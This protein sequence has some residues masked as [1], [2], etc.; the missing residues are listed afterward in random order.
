MESIQT[1]CQNSEFNFHFKSNLDQI[2][3]CERFSCLSSDLH[4]QLNALAELCVRI[5]G[6]EPHRP[7]IQYQQMAVKVHEDSEAP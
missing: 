4:I 1:N 6:V 3:N 2:S 7:G 5:T